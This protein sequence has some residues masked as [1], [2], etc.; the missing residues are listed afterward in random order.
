[1][2]G[3]VFTWASVL[4]R[5]AEAYRTPPAFQPRWY[6]DARGYWVQSCD[7]PQLAVQLTIVLL[8]AVWA[9]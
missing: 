3:D 9:L 6:R 2:V 1:M 5:M 7:K 4:L 8:A